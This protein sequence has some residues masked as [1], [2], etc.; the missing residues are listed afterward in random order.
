LIES[1]SASA[2]LTTLRTSSTEHLGQ[3]ST[4]DDRSHS[5]ASGKGNRVSGRRSRCFHR[6]GTNP[7]RCAINSSCSTDVFS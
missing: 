2:L 3:T 4:P 5:H 7:N 1:P 6:S